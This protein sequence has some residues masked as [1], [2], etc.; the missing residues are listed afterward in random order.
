MF[1]LIRVV[2]PLQ[3]LSNVLNKLK[4][5]RIDNCKVFAIEINKVLSCDTISWY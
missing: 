5:M 1:I 4:E 3:M 2:N